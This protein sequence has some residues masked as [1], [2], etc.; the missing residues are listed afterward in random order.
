MNRRSN[1]WN[2]A[3]LVAARAAALAAG[4]AP[5][6]D[7]ALP[8]ERSTEGA[9]AE[10][11]GSA[12]SEPVSPALA[13]ANDRLIATQKPTYPLDTC[14]VCDQPLA[15]KNAA[16]DVIHAGRLAR[17]CCA[18][19]AAAFSGDPASSIAKIDAAIIASQSAGYPLETCI[20]SGEKLGS[21]G[22]P[23]LEVVG[24]RLVELCCSKCETKLDENPAAAIAKIDAAFADAQRA[25]YP[26]TKCPLMNQAELGSMGEPVEIVY[27][28]R[29]VRL[30]CAACVEEFWANPERT[31]AAL[32]AMGKPGAAKS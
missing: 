23:E 21:M 9:A 28:T 25:A 29:L 13:V 15:S 24:T 6:T 14:V 10:A 32:D 2:A 12:A 8:G 7:T 17:F 3:A 26:V 27:G 20:V 11:A 4:C 5:K 30:C 16:T 31:I 22:D 1:R 19:C 18:D